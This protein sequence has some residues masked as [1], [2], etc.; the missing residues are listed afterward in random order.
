M[1]LNIICALLYPKDFSVPSSVLSSSTILVIE[2]NDTNIAIAKN[3]I[4]NTIL[5]LSTL[6][7]SC[8]KLTYP[9]F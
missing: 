9:L 7:V 4:G 5:K 2:V 1:Y 8:I 3:T 6:C